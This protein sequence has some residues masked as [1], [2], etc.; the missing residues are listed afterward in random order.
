MSATSTRPCSTST[1][2][3]WTP[4]HPRLR[5]WPKQLEDRALLAGKRPLIEN[6]PDLQ[7]LAGQRT[8]HAR[9]LGC[10]GRGRNPTPLAHPL[11]PRAIALAGVAAHDRPQGRIG[12][13]G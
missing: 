8:F 10:S 3:P 13:H 12:L 4:P 9:E 1:C 5:P 7:L 6:A 11:Q 2:E